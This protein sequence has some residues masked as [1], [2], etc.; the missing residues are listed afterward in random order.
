MQRQSKIHRFEVENVASV[1]P[2]VLLDVANKSYK[3]P[4]P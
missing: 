4:P 1:T 2:Q 3:P